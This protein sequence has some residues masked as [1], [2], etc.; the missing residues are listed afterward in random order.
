MYFKT[1]RN[2]KT[3]YKF[4]GLGGE[5]I[6]DYWNFANVYEF[7][8][9]NIQ[10]SVKIFP[11]ELHS[12]LLVS[13]EKILNKSLSKIKE[14]L[15]VDKIDD[16]DLLHN[17]YRE[18]RCRNHFGKG[19]LEDSFSNTVTLTPLLDPELH[20]IKLSSN[21]YVDKN[22]LISL[23]FVRYCPNLLNYKFE[24]KRFIKKDTIEYAN[25][26]NAKNPF[27]KNSNI[28]QKEYKIINS[29]DLY[30][31]LKKDEMIISKKDELSPFDFL[32]TI[33]N[34]AR[35]KYLFTVYYNQ[36]IIDSINIDI[37]KRKYHP[38]THVYGV[39]G[40]TKI[41]NDILISEEIDKFDNVFDEISNFTNNKERIYDLNNEIQ[42]LHN[43]NDDLR[44]QNNI[45]DQVIKQLQNSWSYRIGHLFTYPLS[46]PFEFVKFIRDYNLIKKSNLFDS[47]YYLAKNEDVKKAKIDTIKHYLKFG[48]K[49]GRNP[50]AKFDGNEYLNKRP[51]VRVAGI[52]PLVHYLKFGKDEK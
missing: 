44:N 49:E 23:I 5:C 42:N 32:L 8:K 12:E 15:N 28:I 37:Q 45:Q 29:F 35:L 7:I 1:I 43:Q 52:C 20:K 36:S 22:L 18:T 19:L 11:N 51:D 30:S 27:K 6:R 4:A 25:K 3:F 14:K 47:E 39:I 31:Q 41:I 26:I 33:F 16:I 21:E 48:W 38:L 40:I 24:G 50:S 10:G 17:L 2:V 13:V 9:K 46:I 34:S